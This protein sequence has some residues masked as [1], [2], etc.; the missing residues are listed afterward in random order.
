[1]TEI[2]AGCYELLRPGG[3]LVTVT[4]HTRRGGR[5]LDLAGLTSALVREV[6]FSY[7]GHVVALRVGGDETA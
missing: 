4:K 3:I 5:A 7:I 6:R 1:M 2:Y